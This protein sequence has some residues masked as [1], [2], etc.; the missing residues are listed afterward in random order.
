MGEGGT[1]CD[2]KGAEERKLND[3]GRKRETRG[4]KGRKEARIRSQH[5]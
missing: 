5:R 4:E 1:D 3:R 2:G